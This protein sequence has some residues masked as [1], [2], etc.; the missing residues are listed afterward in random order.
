MTKKILISLF[1][2]PSLVFGQH[3]K[4]EDSLVVACEQFVEQYRIYFHIQHHNDQWYILEPDFAYMHIADSTGSC[5]THIDIMNP[6]G[7]QFFSYHFDVEGDDIYFL[8]DLGIH[9]FNHK[10]EYLNFYGQVRIH[11]GWNYLKQYPTPMLILDNK[12]YY[13]TFLY[14]DATFNIYKYHLTPDA[15]K[16]DIVSVYPLPGLQIPDDSIKWLFPERTFGQR[17]EIYKKQDAFLP[18]LDK[19]YFTAD[20][21][22]NIYF[23]EE[24]TPVISVFNLEGKLL[25]QFGE[26]GKYFEDTLTYMTG[27]EMEKDHFYATRKA[28]RLESYK[29]R[30]I[31]VDS[32]NGLVYRMY[33]TRNY[34]DREK[35]A[36]F[37][38]VYKDGE[39]VLDEPIDLYLSIIK[40]E[41]GIVYYHYQPK[42]RLEHGLIIYKGRLEWDEKN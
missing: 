25:R 20:D 1:F 8:K 23:S 41:N 26:K 7:Y 12:I 14:R 19:R 5:I 38:Q 6:K 11:E 4:V 30:H 21:E 39:L 27:Q 36:G 17:N 42:D 16:T 2:F 35:E 33:R 3:L 9:R 22:M 18:H 31:Y 13:N 10:G 34:I 24:A 28:L 15:Y 40:A 37:I 32:K 29:Y